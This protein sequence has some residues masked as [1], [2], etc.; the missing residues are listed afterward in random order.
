MANILTDLLTTRDMTPI[1][2]T[3][4]NKLSS[5][6]GE[7]SKSVEKIVIRTEHVLRKEGINDF[8]KYAI[9]PKESLQMDFFLS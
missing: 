2:S 7:S 1:L 4:K 9:N 3:E 5:L 6:Q 8:T